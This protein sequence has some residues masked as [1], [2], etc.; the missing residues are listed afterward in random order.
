MHWLH[1][2][3]SLSGMYCWQLLRLYIIISAIHSS[4]PHYSHVISKGDNLLLLS[5]GVCQKSFF[6]ENGKTV[7]L[8]GVVSMC[9][10][11]VNTGVCMCGG[12]SVCVSVVNT[13]VCMCDVVSVCVSVVNTGV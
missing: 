4:W 7:C 10:S 11:V 12:V 8:C 5:A 2:L 9:V 3:T 1:F 6:R 13:G